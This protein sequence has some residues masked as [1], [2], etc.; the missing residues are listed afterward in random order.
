MSFQYF[1]MGFQ[2]V[3]YTFWST[4]WNTCVTYRMA[5]DVTFWGTL[6]GTDILSTIIFYSHFKFFENDH[7]WSREGFVDKTNQCCCPPLLMSPCT[8][9]C[10]ILL[11]LLIDSQICK[12][13][14]DIIRDACAQC[15]THDSPLAL[16]LGGIPSAIVKVLFHYSDNS[17]EVSEINPLTAK[18]LST[19]SDINTIRNLVWVCMHLMSLLIFMLE[20]YNCI[21]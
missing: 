12:C 4:S 20:Y 8:I 9:K 13:T 17:N 16:R 3:R 6:Q 18:K 11:S 2:G 7:W 19:L 5:F 21:L 15:I 10:V 1:L 14:H